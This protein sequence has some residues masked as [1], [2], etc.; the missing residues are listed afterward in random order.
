MQPTHPP[1][2]DDA[3]P[4]RSADVIIRYRSLIRVDIGPIR[5]PPEDD[6]A[7]HPARSARMAD[8]AT[9][10][11]AFRPARRP[12]FVSDLPLADLIR[13]AAASGITGFRAYSE[14]EIR[15]RPDGLSVADAPRWEVWA[16][17]PLPRRPVNGGDSDDGPGCPPEPTEFRRP[18]E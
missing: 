18:R 16:Y 17:Y 11:D 2:P 1:H 4:D 8:L 9:E 5:R 12:D 7:E 15:I 3:S 10:D 13:C 6:D 14:Y